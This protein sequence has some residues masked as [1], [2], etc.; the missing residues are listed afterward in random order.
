MTENEFLWSFMQGMVP[1]CLLV[2]NGDRESSPCSGPSLCLYASTNYL[3]VYEC[4]RCL[5]SINGIT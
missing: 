2:L 5:I 4:M 3:V 1:E